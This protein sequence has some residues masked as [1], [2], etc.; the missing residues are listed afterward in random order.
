M[1]YAVDA[2]GRSIVVGEGFKGAAQ[3]DAASELIGREM[4]LRP[5]QATE[6]GVG[7]PRRYDLLAAD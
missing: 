4:G 7:D 2:A 6:E 1:L 3:A 5:L